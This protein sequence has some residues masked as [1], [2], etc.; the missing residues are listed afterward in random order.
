MGGSSGVGMVYFS[1]AWGVDSTFS[2]ASFRIHSG[3]SGMLRPSGQSTSSVSPRLYLPRCWQLAMPF[4]QLS[5]V[6]TNSHSRM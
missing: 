2:P 6:P 1:I 3:C 4:S 5:T